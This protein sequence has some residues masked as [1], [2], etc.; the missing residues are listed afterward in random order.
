[1]V[2]LYILAMAL[3]IENLHAENSF[4]SVQKV[5]SALTICALNANLDVTASIK[6]SLQTLFEEA[7]TNGGFS[8]HTATAFLDLFPDSER[9]KAYRVYRQCMFTSLGISSSSICGVPPPSHRTRVA[10]G[11]F[12]VGPELRGREDT[13][14]VLLQTLLRSSRQYQV[15]LSENDKEG[16]AKI[17][18]ADPLTSIAMINDTTECS[19]QAEEA[20]LPTADL[21]GQTVLVTVR[22]IDISTSKTLR[23]V[24]SQGSIDSLSD[25]NLLMTSS[26]R[27]IEGGLAPESKVWRDGIGYCDKLKYVLQYGDVAKCT[28]DETLYLMSDRKTG[29]QFFDVCQSTWRKN[30]MEPVCLFECQGRQP[31]N[32]QLYARLKD[33]QLFDR[34]RSA[35]EQRVFIDK[36]QHDYGYTEKRLDVLNIKPI[37]PEEDLDDP[38][39]IFETALRDIR[40]CIANWTT[41][42]E[43]AGDIAGSNADHGS[44]NVTFT[45][46][47]RTFV[48]EL[49]RWSDGKTLWSFLNAYLP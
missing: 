13:L 19:G 17:G 45:N 36:L 4:P 23:I 34:A 16:L 44:K 28:G 42:G 31:K 1:M 49:N 20:F 32:L 2:G 33:S 27:G 46:G 30:E 18:D 40:S 9:L 24:R 14:T 10:L 25:L 26:W 12:T 35:S 21:I 37:Y 6:G 29:N 11:R 15:V 3:R 8:V 43:V 5:Y 22:I 7:S 39:T 41:A 38:D 48:L 47:Q